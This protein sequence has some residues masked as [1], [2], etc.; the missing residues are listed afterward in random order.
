MN[1]IGE[2][3]SYKEHDDHFTLIISGKTDRWKVQLMIVWTLAWLFC[4]GAVLYYMMYSDYP[5]DQMIFLW[6]FMGFWL[7]FLYKITRVLFWRKFGIE[8]IRLDSDRLTIKR[9]ILGYGVAKPFLIANVIKV[10]LTELKEK[11]F[12]KVFNDSFWVLGQGTL[13]VVLNDQKINFGSQ[14]DSDSGKKLIK[15]INNQIKKHQLVG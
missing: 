12:S 11:S 10:E 14:L 6:I 1:W 7:Y 2:R 8:F 13:E 15:L 4:G 3:I 5:K 9:S